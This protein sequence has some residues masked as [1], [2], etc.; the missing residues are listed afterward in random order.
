[1]KNIKTIKKKVHY[2]HNKHVKT[3][4]WWVY[5]G[6]KKEE[7]TSV[8]CEPADT[9]AQPPP[10]FEGWKRLA[11]HREQ[12]PSTHHPV[13]VTDDD[14]MGHN[15]ELTLRRAEFFNRR[16]ITEFNRESKKL[17]KKE[18]RKRKQQRR[19]RHDISHECSEVAA[20]AVFQ[21]KHHYSTPNG[22]CGERIALPEVMKATKMVA[23]SLL[24]PSP[25]HFFDTLQ[26][27]QFDD[28]AV[29]EVSRAI[30]RLNRAWRL[31]D[32]KIKEKRQRDIREQE[33]AAAASKARLLALSPILLPPDEMPTKFSMLTTAPST[34]D[35]EVPEDVLPSFAEHPPPAMSSPDDSVFRTPVVPPR[36]RRQP[37]LRRTRR[38]PPRGYESSSA[39]SPTS[40]EDDTINDAS[41]DPRMETDFGSGSDAVV[42]VDSLLPY[43]MRRIL[44]NY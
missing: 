31:H 3:R 2:P 9:M 33:D 37:A 25:E 28:V 8:V 26:D 14:D 27:G 7:K 35:E 17:S 44:R 21:D 15:T 11:H 39:F 4:G 36:R 19:H 20:A 29:S 42:D 22:C 23:A 40:E 18:V 30:E 32:A 1:M 5:K 16:L 6:G 10:T 12:L 34:S 24:A 38:P 13:L 43:S 41:Y